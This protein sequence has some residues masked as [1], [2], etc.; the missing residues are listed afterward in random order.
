MKA[1]F[2][3][4]LAVLLSAMLL[5]TAVPFAASAAAN[6]EQQVGAKS[7]TTGD[8]TWTLDNNGTLTISGSGAMDNYSSTYYNDSHTFSH[9]L[10]PF[11]FNDIAQRNGSQ[12]F[13]RKVGTFENEKMMLK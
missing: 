1:L 10:S 6:A 12:R 8:C 11:S 3:K 13:T 2:T 5:F 9:G 4:T 7:G